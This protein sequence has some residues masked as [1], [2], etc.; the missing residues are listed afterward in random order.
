ML[1]KQEE[2]RATW[3]I[4]KKVLFNYMDEKDVLEYR[5]FKLKPEWK[6][7]R[8]GQREYFNSPRDRK[9]VGC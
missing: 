4:I 7:V 2:V 5:L 6:K 8:S 3:K 9:E 1:C